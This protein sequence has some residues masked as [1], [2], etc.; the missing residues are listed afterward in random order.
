[1]KKTTSI[2]LLFLLLL[3]NS[4][5]HIKKAH[6]LS[7]ETLKKIESDISPGLSTIKADLILNNHNLHPTGFCLGDGPEP[8]PQFYKLPTGKFLCI[9]YKHSENGF[10]VSNISVSTKVYPALVGKADPE[11]NDFWDSFKDVKTFNLKT[12]K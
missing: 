10:I 7:V 9:D 6:T 1:M 11:M 8:N 2:I 12:L 4:C 3:L 5:G